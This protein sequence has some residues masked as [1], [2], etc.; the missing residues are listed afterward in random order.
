MFSSS[1]V[2][3]ATEGLLTGTTRRKMAPYRAAGQFR[4]RRSATAHN[5]GNIVP[6]HGVVAGIFALGRKDDVN[7][8][9]IERARH[10]QAERVAGFSSSGTTTSSVVPG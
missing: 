4:G 5:L 2:I 9:L 7:A 10:L 6:G 3:S 1:L 8:G